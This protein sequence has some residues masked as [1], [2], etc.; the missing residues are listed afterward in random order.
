MALPALRTPPG[1]TESARTPDAPQAFRSGPHLGAQFDPEATVDIVAERALDAAQLAALGIDDGA[2]LLTASPRA[3][4]AAAAAA[5]RRL[6]DAF[7]AAAAAEAR[8]RC[9]VGRL[10]QGN[11]Q[12]IQAAEHLIA[13]GVRIGHVH[14]RT[15][16]IDRVRDFYVGVLGFNTW[17]SA[18]AGR[19]PTASRGSIT[20]RS[21]TRRAP[22]SPRSSATSTSTTCFQ[23]PRGRKGGCHD[24]RTSICSRSRTR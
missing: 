12:P 11:I 24:T 14:L 19:S 15:A 3:P 18:A 7:L 5:F 6:F 20:S 16:D 13:P 1:A 10:T 21:T 17:K 9:T 22:G 2:A 8:P 23:S 4:G